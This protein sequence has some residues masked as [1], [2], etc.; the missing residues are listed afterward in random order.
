MKKRTTVSTIFVYVQDTLLVFYVHI[1]RTHAILPDQHFGGP[2]GHFQI[3]HT[4][5]SVPLVAPSLE[6]KKKLKSS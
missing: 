4:A 2:S 5:L 1:Q 3:F 6:V